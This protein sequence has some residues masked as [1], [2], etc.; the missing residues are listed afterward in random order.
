QPAHLLR[1]ALDGDPGE[2]AVAAEDP[3]VDQH[4]HAGPAYERPHQPPA[5]RRRQ[6][7]LDRTLA[8]LHQIDAQRPTRFGRIRS[9]T[10]RA[11]ARASASISTI[12]IPYTG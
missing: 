2:G 12:K 11:S 9:R 4:A 5:G 6:R 3:V 1:E 10:L 8:E 7:A